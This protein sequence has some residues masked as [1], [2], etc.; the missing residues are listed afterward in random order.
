MSVEREQRMVFGEVAQT[1]HDVRP[2]YPEALFDDLIAFV[3]RSRPLS[4]EVGAGTGKATLAIAARGASVVALEPSAAMAAIARQTCRDQPEVSIVV[5][6]FERW[7][8]PSARFDLVFSAQ[9]WHWVD[10]SIGYAKAYEM[11]HPGGVLALFW[12][13]P[14]WED[15]E[16]RSKLDQIYSCH[17]PELHARAPGYPGLR[18]R[19]LDQEQAQR[20]RDSALFD[21]PDIR[22]YRWSLPYSSDAYVRLLTTQSDHRMLSAP[23]RQRLLDAVRDTIDHHGGQ[24]TVNYATTLFLTRRRD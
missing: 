22:L 14:T 15:S 17:A 18:A 9:A 24:L 21:D 23:V 10:A 11:L 16:L 20:I 13:R 1:Y 3:R 7:Q 5:S 4:L 6:S 19:D 12:N 8:I 2:G